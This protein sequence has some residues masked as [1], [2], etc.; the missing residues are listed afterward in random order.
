MK[1]HADSKRGG[2]VGETGLVASYLRRESADI[3]IDLKDF[4]TKAFYITS[5]QTSHM[6]MDVPMYHEAKVTIRIM[7]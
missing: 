3:V 5:F 4:A 1:R 6:N 7:I 2:E